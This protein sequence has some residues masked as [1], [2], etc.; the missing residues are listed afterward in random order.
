V[1]HAAI[2][3]ILEFFNFGDVMVG[4]VMTLL[5]GRVS[6]VIV[7]DGYSDTVK[8]ARG[9][10]QGDRA[11]PYIFIIVIE[12]LLIKLRGMEGHGVECCD[13]IKRKIEGMDIEP[14]N[15]EAYADDLTVIFKMDNGTVE[16]VLRVL[17][18][19]HKY[20]VLRLTRI[21]HN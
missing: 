10:P 13:F 2:K 6:R 20:Q 9:T 4:M 8:I 17:S 5:N 11:S 18:D 15:A 19:L 21:R 16:V 1:E 7:E 3:M 14:L 12:I